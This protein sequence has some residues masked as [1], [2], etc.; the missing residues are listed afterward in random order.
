MTTTVL[1]PLS[2]MHTALE[3]AED[4]VLAAAHAM[5]PLVSATM[6]ALF[7][8]GAFLVIHGAAGLSDYDE[9]QLNS[10]RDA[11]GTILWDGDSWDGCECFPG[12]LPAEIAA[13]WHGAEDPIDPGSV[14]WLL[15]R[16]DFLAPYYHLPELPEEL[17]HEGEER[18][19]LRCIPIAPAPAAGET[20]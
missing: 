13:L 14:L 2:E 3:E 9:L 1:R 20:V 19:A 12:P 6:H 7:P 15:R 17:R 4:Q 18:R 10:V 8:T 16:I 5:L 11:T